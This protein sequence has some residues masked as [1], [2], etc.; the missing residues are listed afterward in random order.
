MAWEADVAQA[1]A[2][3]NREI[4]NHPHYFV[5]KGRRL[6]ATAVWGVVV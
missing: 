2:G 3:A 4:G 5:D 6:P 1:V